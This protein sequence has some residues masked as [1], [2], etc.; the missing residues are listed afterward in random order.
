MNLQTLIFK[1]SVQVIQLILPKK[2]LSIE[3]RQSIALCAE[4][5]AE[6]LDRVV[7]LENCSVGRVEYCTVHGCRVLSC[8]LPELNLFVVLKNGEGFAGAQLLPYDYSPTNRFRHSKLV[9]TCIPT[10]TASEAGYA[11][12]IAL[13]YIHVDLVLFYP[14][15]TLVVCVRD[16]NA[17]AIGAGY[18]N[19]VLLSGKG[20]SGIQRDC[21]EVYIEDM[22]MLDTDYAA[23]LVDFPR[24]G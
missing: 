22:Q 20:V 9:V 21:S 2:L 5:S 10:D 7:E 17:E 16:D 4:A 24:F 19:A 3:V 14:L 8:D 18:A 11:R 6:N 12:A 23:S 13:P 1:L 15:G